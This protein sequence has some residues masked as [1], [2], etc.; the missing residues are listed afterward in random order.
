MSIEKALEELKSLPL[1]S[2]TK[3][4]EIIEEIEEEKKQ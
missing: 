4:R 1:E 2:L 3:L